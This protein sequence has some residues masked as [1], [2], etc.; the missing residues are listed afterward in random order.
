MGRDL[1]EGDGELKAWRA[2]FPFKVGSISLLALEDGGGRYLIEK[3][4]KNPERRKMMR[5]SSIMPQHYGKSMTQIL[6]GS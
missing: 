2:E 1:G 5:R 4:F 3:L 6:K